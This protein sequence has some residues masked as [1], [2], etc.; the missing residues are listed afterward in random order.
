MRMHVTGAVAL[1]IGGLGLSSPAVRA[2]DPGEQI[3]ALQAI[4]RN[5]TPAERKLDSRLAVDLRRSK[6]RTTVEVDIQVRDAKA[7]LVPRLRALG[8]NVRYVSPNSGAIRAAVASGAIR[9]IAGWGEVER[10]DPAALAKTMRMGGKATT[11]EERGAAASANARRAAAAVVSEGV[12]A[13]GVDTV[14]QR[15]KV[16]GIGVK[17]CVLSDG[18]DSLAASQASGE[19]PP[20]VD[21]LPGEEGDGDEGTAMLEI[22]HDMA[23]GAKLG[24]ATA[25]TSDASFADNI[26]ALRFEAGC[27]V[28]ADDVLYFNE[29]PFQDGPIA[30][31]VNAVTADG[32]LYFSSAGNEGNT[33]DGTS[34]NYEGDFRG[35]GESV[36][37]FA[38]EAHDFD[39]GPA[40]Q[41]FEPI[42]DDSSAGVPVTLHWA[43]PLDHAS[44]DYDL[45]LFDATGAIVNFSQDVQDGDDDP[46]EILGTPVFGADGLRLA[47]VRFKGEPR[48]FQLS[49]LGSRFSDAPGLPAWVTAG[50]TRGHSAAE[51]AFSMAAAPA[52]EPLPFDLEPGD[53]PNP[54]GPFPGVFTSAQLPERFTSDGPRRMF[55]AADGTP[56]PQTRSKPDF[57]AADGV[58]TSVPDFEQFF[59]T[60]AAAPSA[61]GIAALVRSGNPTATIADVR[62]AFAAT[63][64]DLAPAGVDARSGHGILRA[65]DV[66]AYTG[67]TPQPLVEAQ[68]PAVVTSADGDLFLEPGET[69]T[70]RI[71]VTNTGDGTATGISA[72]VTS[73]DADVTIA[74]R[75]RSYGD[76][77]PG[78]SIAR[79]FTVTLAAGHRLGKPIT[80]A[81]RLTFAGSLSPTL[82]TFKVGV[83]QPASTPV[84]VSYTGPAIL[85]PDASTLGASVPLEVSGVGFASKIE[86]SVD[87]TACSEDPA[88]TTVGINH[89]YVGDLTGTLTSPA[90][91][92]A[93]LFQRR[94]ATGENLC[95]VVFDDAAE[96]PFASVTA[97]DDPFTGTWR[98]QTPLADLIEDAVDG[99]WTFKVTDGAASDTGSLRAVTLSLTGFVG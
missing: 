89:S 1:A 18:V 7:D 48:F 68:Q 40:V 92:T 85:I 62:D 57:T 78:A 60:S 38:G 22:V 33:I 63:A 37:K 52:D 17:V 26:R 35:S 8:A 66:L 77:P 55:F 10:V 36:G 30:Q 72:V 76:L 64:L 53:P 88:S 71:P 27:D 65:D 59:G 29:S 16:T 96:R 46:Y 67:A 80:I 58:S 11:K 32:A 83:G 12:A 13:H 19:L 82:A 15:D 9:A 97:T 69:A 70:L 44:D 3:A 98:P 23:P 61:A 51:Q 5:L 14:L 43:D 95:Q 34:G 45:Y 20:D 79:E 49:A 6:I 39:P 81:V 24:F 84:K 31:S 74:P 4:K 93:I 73:P 47:V 28:I 21:V 54:R 87:G 86:F 99:T 90:G 75:T 56:A 2:A 25:F 42:S 50:V 91:K 94:G 41:V